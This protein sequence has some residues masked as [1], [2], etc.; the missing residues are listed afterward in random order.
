M[1]HLNRRLKLSLLCEWCLDA[2]L[3]LAFATQALLLGCLITYGYIPL[4][5]DWTNEQLRKQAIKGLYLQAEKIGF[6]LNGKLKLTE[7]ALYQESARL[8]LLTAN[9]ITIHTG[10]FTNG[11]FIPSIKSIAL[12]NGNLSLPAVY[13]ADGSHTTILDQISLRLIPSPERLHIDTFTAAHQTIRLRGSI[14]LPISTLGKDDSTKDDPLDDFYKIVADIL[15][16]KAYT[17]IF[18][19]PSITFEVKIEEEGSVRIFTKLSSR[20]IQ[21]SDT[22]GEY[23]SI[24]TALRYHDGNLTCEEPIFIELEKLHSPKYALT[25]HS[26]SAQLSQKDWNG[27]LKGHFPDFELAAERLV[28]RH[29]EIHA[30]KIFIHPQTYPR[31]GIS[32]STSGFRGE[33][34]FHGELDA[35]KHNGWIKTKGNLDISLLIPDSIRK[36]IPVLEFESPPYCDLLVEFDDGF[37]LNSAH[38]GVTTQN[39]S[40]AEIAFETLQAKG[41]Y[42]NGLLDLKKV[43]FERFGQWIDM[44]FTHDSLANQ[45]RILI[46]GSIIPDQYNKIMPRWWNNIFNEDFSFSSNSQVY[47]DFAVHGNTLPSTTELCF[48]LVQAAQISYVDIPIDQ[49]TLVLR[50]RDTYTELHELNA[51]SGGGQLKG[52]IRFISF[53]D[54]IPASACIRYDVDGKLPL[55]STRKLFGPEVAKIIDDFGSSHSPEVHLT[56]A[57]FNE[58]LYPQFSG[59][60]FITLTADSN[61]PIH[62][63]DVPLDYLR[64]TL[65]ANETTTH[66]RNLDFGYADGTGSG[67][68]DIKNSSEAETA[69]LRLKLHLNEADYDQAI[70]NLSVF[71]GFEKSFS[72]QATDMSKSKEHDKARISLDLHAEGPINNLYQLSGAGK[73]ELDDKKLGA[74]QLLGPLSKALQSTPLGFTSFTF[75]KMQS[76]F[77]IADEQLFFREIS[78]DGPKTK[79]EANGTM[80][81]RD[82][83]LNMKVSVNLF[84]NIGN[85]RLKIRQ[86][87]EAL[88]PLTYLLKFHLTGTV[89]KQRLRSI[90]DPRNLLTF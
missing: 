90:F 52:D 29:I 59:K 11:R 73:F 39:L 56:G 46:N 78:I 70:N 72:N 58:E 45:Y 41:S 14:E 65:D 35:L 62:Y 51:Y 20:T 88:N 79:I 28:I 66:L 9:A 43:G 13:A 21:Y 31:I 26:F 17:P 55:E 57:H 22:N 47:G 30:P 42:S 83:S 54:G 33:F 4:P 2:I 37:K 75:E 1:P 15:K 85:D 84:E 68:I 7:I 53:R 89:K 71:E 76:E 63:Q 61:G 87:I 40:V 69:T 23:L 81:L 36:K 12:S 74:I 24:Q 38:F 64:F 82:Q 50:K 25:A 6:H 86:A 27:L 80:Q 77:T 16:R 60:S 48:G 44:Q 34:G 32:G 18:T 67:M 5:K 3:I 8:P 10:L 49:G 19:N